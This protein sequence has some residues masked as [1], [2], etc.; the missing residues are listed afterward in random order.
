MDVKKIISEVG[1]FYKGY[2]TTTLHLLDSRGRLVFSTKTFRFL[3]DMTGEEFYK[4]IEGTSGFFVAEKGGRKQL[5][6]Y[7]KSVSY[8]NLPGMD[9]TLVIGHDVRE[10]IQPLTRLRRNLAA[11]FL[12]FAVVVGAI[13]LF[14]SR[15][16]TLPLSKLTEGVE[17]IGDGELGYRVPVERNDEIGRVA[18]SF[19]EMTEKRQ[20]VEENLR[21]SEEQYRKLATELAEANK[22]L[23]AFSYSVSHDL[24]TPLRT[25]SGF[26]SILQE[27][28][29][30]K[31]DDEG[32]RLL[33][34]IELPLH[35]HAPLEAE[36]NNGVSTQKAVV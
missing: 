25:I 33:G 7:S 14:L 28:Y 29:E 4:K 9:W 24:R 5:F 34:I 17:R 19:N 10:V 23:E 31:L 2:K 1:I 30:S 26:S 3:E 36:R 15:S 11:G 32:R 12:I 27:E 20:K 16:I 35:Q 8:R 22:E 18:N 13:A 21:Q 6:S